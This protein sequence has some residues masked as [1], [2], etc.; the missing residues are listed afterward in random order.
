ARSAKPATKQPHGGCDTATTPAH[1]GAATGDQQPHDFHHA[2]RA[3]KSPV[4]PMPNHDIRGPR[5]HAA[6]DHDQGR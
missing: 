4:P 6:R 1:D 5:A 3:P 2:G